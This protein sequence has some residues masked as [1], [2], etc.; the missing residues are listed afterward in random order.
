MRDNLSLFT[1]GVNMTIPPRPLAVNVALF[2]LWLLF[3]LAGLVPL[4]SLH[5]LASSFLAVLGFSSSST[6]VL[7]V[8]SAL[9]SSLFSLLFVWLLAWLFD[10]LSLHLFTIISLA[11]AD[12]VALYHS[13]EE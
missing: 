2:L 13:E 6:S 9:F 11:V 8:F 5:L 1:R 10:S 12:G 7:A 4:L 3:T